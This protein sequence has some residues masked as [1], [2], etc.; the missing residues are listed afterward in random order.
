MQVKPVTLRSWAR[1]HKIPGGVK[2][3]NLWFFD[4][5]RLAEFLNERRAG[6]EDGS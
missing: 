6:V 3:G 4:R 2:L 1:Q 5:D